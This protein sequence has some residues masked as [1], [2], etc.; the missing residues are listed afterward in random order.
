MAPQPEAELRTSLLAHTGLGSVT[1]VWNV[2]GGLQIL[3]P[4]STDYEN[5]WQF[6]EPQSD[7]PW[8]TWAMPW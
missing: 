3:P 5:G 1:L 6:V 7:A 2:L 8:S 4:G